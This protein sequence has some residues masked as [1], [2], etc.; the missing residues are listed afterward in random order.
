MKLLSFIL[1]FAL[2]H[3]LFI[4][5]GLIIFYSS[6]KYKLRSFGWRLVAY[7]LASCFGIPKCLHQ[8]LSDNCAYNPTDK[9]FK[10]CKYWTCSKYGKCVYSLKEEYEGKCKK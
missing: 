2:W 6:Y 4:A 3:W 8:W 7:G 10:R 1:V 9:R 5:L